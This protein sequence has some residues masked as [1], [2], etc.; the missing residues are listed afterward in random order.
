MWRPCVGRSWRTKPHRYLSHLI[1]HESEGS[2]LLALKKRGWVDS[3]CAGSHAHPVGI[4]QPRAQ[5]AWCSRRRDA[6]RIGLCALR[7]ADDAERG[8]RRAHC[9]DHTRCAIARRQLRRARSLASALCAAVFA[10]IRM[11]AASP[12][13]RWVFDECRAMGEMAFRFR[14][15]DEPIDAVGWMASALEHHPADQ[16]ISRDL[17]RFC[18]SSLRDRMRTTGDLRWLPVLRVR[19]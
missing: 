12:P 7:G 4:P 16:A 11:L 6:R 3:L 9:R 8:G 15:V 19:P 18:A 14:E 2:L 5:R 17:A 1:G 13:A 10:Y